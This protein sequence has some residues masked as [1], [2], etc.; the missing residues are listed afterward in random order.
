MTRIIDSPSKRR[1]AKLVAGLALSALL[2]LGAFVA[3]ASAENWTAQQTFQKTH[4]GKQDHDRRGGDRGNDGDRGYYSAPPVVYGAPYGG[5]YYGSP[6]PVVYGPGLNI[7][8][9]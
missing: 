9:W 4:Q 2:V 3:S 8:I 6:P 5:G 7:N 1:P